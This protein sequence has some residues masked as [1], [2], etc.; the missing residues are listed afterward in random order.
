MKPLPE[1]LKQAVLV[2]ANFAQFAPGQIYHF[3]W[4]ASRMILWCKAGTGTM[5]VNGRK[6]RFE[7]RHYLLL[8]GRLILNNCRAETK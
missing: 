4:V 5:V 7:A 8:P 6:V 3:P 2:Y 1:R